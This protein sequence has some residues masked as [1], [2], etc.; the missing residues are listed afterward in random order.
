MTNNN[1]AIRAM[2]IAAFSAL[3]SKSKKEFEYSCLEEKV[4]NA[5]KDI[6]SFKKE[7][8]YNELVLKRDEII[9]TYGEKFYNKA[10]AELDQQFNVKAKK[11]K[12]SRIKLQKADDKIAL[13]MS[14]EFDMEILVASF[15]AT[16]AN[17]QYDEGLITFVEL[18]CSLLNLI[19]K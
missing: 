10:M 16:E 17:V 2:F 15:E 11:L 18:T 6:Q 12:A 4:L 1:A 14:R 5:E 9:N 7:S 8:G 13:V 3:L 19:I